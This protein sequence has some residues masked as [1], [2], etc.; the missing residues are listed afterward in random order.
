MPEL[1]L[2]YW[3]G[4]RYLVEPFELM[5]FTLIYDGDLP[6]SANKSRPAEAS[7]EVVPIRWTG[8]RVS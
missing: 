4:A 2:S 6:A 1:P 5:K 7:R 8:T 3:E